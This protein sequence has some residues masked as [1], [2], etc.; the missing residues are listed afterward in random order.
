VVYDSDLAKAAKHQSDI[1]KQILELH[2][3]EERLRKQLSFW[4]NREDEMVRRDLKSLD[5]LDRLEAEE[6][7]ATA[8]AQQVSLATPAPS[9]EFPDLLVDWDLA[10]LDGLG[11]T[12]E[13]IA[14]NSQGSG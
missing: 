13:P 10:G 5:E 11:G 3:K 8:A 12:P 9:S 14:N 7:A 4:Q 6:R 1:R 2:Q